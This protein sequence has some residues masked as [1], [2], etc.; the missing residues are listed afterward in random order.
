MVNKTAFVALATL[1]LAACATTTRS[2]G[3]VKIAT[4]ADLASP[5][6]RVGPTTCEA[7]GTRIPRRSG[8]ATS[9]PCRQYS[10]EDIERTGATSL[11]DALR[12]L[13][14]SIQ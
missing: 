2:P 3:D 13:D 1:G 10:G 9:Q 7:T 6:T 11:E 8:E 4:A 14:P 5:S 12:M